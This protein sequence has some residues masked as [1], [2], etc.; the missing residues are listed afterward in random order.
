M[1]S[2]TSGV[3]IF[4]GPLD[5]PGYEEILVFCE[6]VHLLDRVAGRQEL[7]QVFVLRLTSFY[8]IAVVFFL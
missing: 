4:Q 5:A 8:E 7:P 1:Q 6:V 2:I 3:G